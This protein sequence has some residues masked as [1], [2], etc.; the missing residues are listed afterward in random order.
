MLFKIVL[1]FLCLKEEFYLGWKLALWIWSKY[2][3]RRETYAAE[4]MEYDCLNETTPM[5]EPFPR[6]MSIPTPIPRS[7]S[8]PT[9]S[10]A[11]VLR[12]TP[13]KNSWTK[14]L[15]NYIISTYI[16]LPL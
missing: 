4:E 15:E 6:G 8:I 12:E 7:M 1:C 10:P 14:L 2:L 16:R 9:P 3:F 11:P 5:P 13:G